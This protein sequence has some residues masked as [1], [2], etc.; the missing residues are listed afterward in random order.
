M[1]VQVKNSDSPNLLTTDFQKRSEPNFAA[2]NVGGV[3]QYLP[4]V[5][6][7]WPVTCRDQDNNLLDL[8]GAGRTLSNNGTI[9]FGYDGLL[10]YASLVGASSQYFSRSDEAGL[11]TITE[12]MTFGL[13]VNFR[14]DGSF[15]VAG[16]WNAGANTRSWRISRV[17]GT[18]SLTLEC[19]SNG[20]AGTVVTLNG[21]ADRV[22]VNTWLF[23]AARFTMGAEMALF[24]GR[25]KDTLAIGVPANPYST[26]AQLRIGTDG[27]SGVFGTFYMGP[28]LLCGLALPDS[29]IYHFYEQT[30]SL[31]GPLS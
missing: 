8:C 4:G 20:A 13:W 5:R 29:H 28:G 6:A 22:P 30:R 23:I 7:G 27:D 16:R 21:T 25:D 24:V 10:N 11:D 18:D 9:L 2:V 3:L 12:G 17:L 31:F 26:N 14:L 1:P 15:P 19:S